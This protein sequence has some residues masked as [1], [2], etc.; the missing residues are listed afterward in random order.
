MTWFMNFGDQHYTRALNEVDPQI[1]LSQQNALNQPVDNPF[2]NYL[3]PQLFPGQLRNQRQV[4]LGSLLRP[5]PQYG[6]LYTIGNVGAGERY[7]SLELKAQKMYSRGFNFLFAY[8]YIR[9]KLQINNF[10]DLDYFSNT[11]Q[12]AGQQSTPTSRH[13]G[14]YVGSAV[15]KGTSINGDAS[16][17]VDAAIGGWKI[18]GVWTYSTGAFVRFGN[19]IA[20]GSPCLDNPTP[21]RW[22]DTSVFSRLPAN[23]YVVRNNPMQYDCLTGPRF[24]QLDATLTKDFAVTERVRVE[25]KMAAYNA[26]NSLN[27]AGSEYRHQQLSIR[28]GFVPGYSGVQLWRANA[29]ARQ[30][31]RADRLNSGLKIRF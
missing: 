24:S 4:S 6:P 12:L 15:R 1:R 27:R 31:H 22:F 20:N 25:L 29:R 19:L 30:Y 23:T 11:F 8:V 14:R 21:E 7:N 2:Y 17:A 28:T 5:Y 16:R 18:A 10:N 3:T 26:T 13:C 9:E